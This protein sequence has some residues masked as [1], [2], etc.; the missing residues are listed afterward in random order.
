MVTVGMNY[1]VLPG[2]EE[3]FENAFSQVLKVMSEDEGHENSH[4]YKDVKDPNS[5][6]IVSEW[7]DEEAF[8]AFVRS[9]KFGKVT[10]WGK[11]QILAGRP[12]HQV[13]RS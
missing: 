3:V 6:L 5:Y 8:N 7:G 4:L 2:K 12:K 11:E 13:Y 9:E 10:N 1:Q